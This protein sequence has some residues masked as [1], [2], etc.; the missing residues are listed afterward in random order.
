MSMQ[1]KRSE[2]FQTI[3]KF[4]FSRRGAPFFL[5]SQEIDLIS[6]WERQG[7]PLD[8]VL[9]GMREQFDTTDRAFP[10]KRRRTLLSCRNSVQR[11]FEQSRERGVGSKRR[12]PSE[13]RMKV[14]AVQREVASFLSRIPPEVAGL[15]EIYSPLSD[16][17]RLGKA[18]EEELER[19]DQAVEAW[20]CAH[21]SSEDRIDAEQEAAADL[22]TW[23]EREK[24]RL[25]DIRLARYLRH[26]YRVPFLSPF[27]Y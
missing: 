20:L 15:R 19:A 8:A 26:K 6:V 24:Q 3:A 14:K 16:I 9:N 12:S 18:D 1:N 4:L 22:T 21:A 17:L 13:P 7:I 5:S 11:A 27:Y 25:R 23:G 10:G 2:Y